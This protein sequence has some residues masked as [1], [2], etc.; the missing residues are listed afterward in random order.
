MTSIF[1]GTA[2]AAA[3]VLAMSAGAGSAMAESAFGCQ[4]LFRSDFMPSLEGTEGYFFRVE[5]DLQMD[6]RLEPEVVGQL[7]ELSRVLEARG[8]TLIYVPIPS[9]ALI[10]PQRLPPGARDLGYDL[11]TAAT[12]YELT[13]RDLREAGVQTVNARAALLATPGAASPV[14]QV[15]PRLTAAG[16]EALAAAV[17]TAVTEV[18]RYPRVTKTLYRTQRDGTETI[19]SAMRMKLQDFCSSPLPTVTTERFRTFRSGTALSASASIG[20]SANEDSARL[21]V[22]GSEISGLPAS[23]LA[24]FLAEALQLDTGSVVV[25]G[26]D[27]LAAITTYLSSAAFEQ[28]PPD[29]I[30]W[31]HPIWS[32]L[33]AR[34][35][36]PM[37]ALLAAAGTSCRAPLHLDVGRDGVGHADLSRIALDPRLTLRLD[38]GADARIVRFDFEGPEG[39]LRSRSIHLHPEQTSISRFFMPLSALWDQG[40]TRVSIALDTSFGAR[41]E[42]M[43]CDVEG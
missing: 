9:K 1:K 43:L 33:A 39:L 40:A 15:D 20:I 31:T 25:P 42:L 24:G 38:A 34:G 8:T 14:F 35:D 7:A 30:V 23:N 11:V 6:H 10:V 21:M 37:R 2:R 29:F 32:S 36:Q 3:V 18:E 27:G 13:L 26:E 22:V 5:P 28:S 41:P 12:I 16:A 4:E 17:A 19:P